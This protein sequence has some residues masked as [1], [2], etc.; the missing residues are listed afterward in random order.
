M[1]THSLVSSKSRYDSATSLGP[2]SSPSSRSP[3]IYTDHKGS[4]FCGEEL[5]GFLPSFSVPPSTEHV[6]D[7]SENFAGQYAVPLTAV[8]SDLEMADAQDERPLPLAL[9]WVYEQRVLAMI[10]GEDA[11]SV[12]S[13]GSEP[14]PAYEP[15]G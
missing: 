7:R 6:P 13:C 15:C 9:S 14:L 3:A 12:D 11:P 5:P 1:R 2:S 4:G 8:A 10:A